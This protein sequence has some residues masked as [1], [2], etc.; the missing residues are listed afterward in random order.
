[1]YVAWVRLER[2]RQVGAWDALTN[3]STFTASYR[4]N[5]RDSWVPLTGQVTDTQITYVGG[6]VRPA[7]IPPGLEPV[8]N[9][10]R[11][12]VLLRNANGGSR[13]ALIADNLRISARACPDPGT[14][15]V[16]STLSAEVTGLTAGSNNYRFV[17]TGASPAVVGTPSDPSATVNLPAAPAPALA[18]APPR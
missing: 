5:V 8:A 3:P 17:V 18:R 2:T 15:R 6:T 9:K 11:V 13:A 12:G 7:T 16:V 14:V 1:M 10:I 4:L